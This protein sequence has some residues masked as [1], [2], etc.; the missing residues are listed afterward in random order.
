MQVLF[1][2]YAIWQHYYT[3]N[4]I[5]TSM[6]SAAISGFSNDLQSPV[7]RAFQAEFLR[8]H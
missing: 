6:V 1:I 4:Y 3:I 7:F 8:L 2:R 5:R